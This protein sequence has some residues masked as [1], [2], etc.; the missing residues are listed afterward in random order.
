M[1]VIQTMIHKQGIDAVISSVNTAN[2]FHI[3]LFA[4]SYQTHGKYL[5]ILSI[6]GEK[7]FIFLY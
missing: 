5:S 6:I 2:F 4:E 7:N 3:F 1:K